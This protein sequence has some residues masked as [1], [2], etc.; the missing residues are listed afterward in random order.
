[1]QSPI[2]WKSTCAAVVAVVVVDV[3]VREGVGRGCGRAIRRDHVWKLGRRL[4]EV[5]LL[6]WSLMLLRGKQGGVVLVSSFSPGAAVI[7][8]RSGHCGSPRTT[9]GHRGC[10]LSVGFGGGLHGGKR[11]HVCEEEKS[12]MVNASGA[13]CPPRAIE[14]D[15]DAAAAPRV[16]WSTLLPK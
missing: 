9:T 11:V 4:L 15:D 7:S 1:M 2:G 10:V 13:D 12:V 3:V 16:R 5:Q 8:K 6:W 14:D